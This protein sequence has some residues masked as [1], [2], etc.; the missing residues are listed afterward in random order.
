VARADE[1]AA[2]RKELIDALRMAVDGEHRFGN[3][4]DTRDELDRRWNRVLELM[5]GLW[6]TKRN[7]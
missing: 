1:Q 6:L 5:E 2:K 3:R 4:V 7:R